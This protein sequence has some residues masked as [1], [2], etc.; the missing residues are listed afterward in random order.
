MMWCD[1]PEI[2][3]GLGNATDAERAYTGFM[4]QFDHGFMLQTDT[5]ET[6]VFYSTGVWH[7][8]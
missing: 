5:R 1:I 7:I 4:Q 3:A 6:F 2:R 8:R